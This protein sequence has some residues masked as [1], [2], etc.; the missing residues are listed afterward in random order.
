MDKAEALS[1][2]GRIER[3]IGVITYNLLCRYADK[4]QLRS[5]KG[6]EVPRERYAATIHRVAALGARNV[7]GTVSGVLVTKIPVDKMSE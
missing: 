5:R 7:F 1:W 6:V 4:S 2:D 3:G